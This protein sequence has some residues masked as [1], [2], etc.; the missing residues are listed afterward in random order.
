MDEERERE[1]NLRREERER[2]E[3]LRR[4]ERE[5]VRQ[6]TCVS[7]HDCSANRCFRHEKSEG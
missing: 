7:H 6:T 1:E 2:E 4:E 3:N 5:A